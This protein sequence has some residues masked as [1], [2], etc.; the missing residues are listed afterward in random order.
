MGIENQSKTGE[1]TSLAKTLSEMRKPQ[2]A[3][4]VVEKAAVQQLRHKMSDVGAKELANRDEDGAFKEVREAVGK[5]KEVSEKIIE[6]AAIAVPGSQVIAAEAVLKETAKRV[7]KEIGKAVVKEVASQAIDATESESLRRIKGKIVE[8]SAATVEKGVDG[9]YSRSGDV[10]DSIPTE[11]PYPRIRQASAPEVDIAKESTAE[12]ETEGRECEVVGSEERSDISDDESDVVADK[13]E[14]ANH[15]TEKSVEEGKETPNLNDDQVDDATAYV[16]EI[17]PEGSM[18]ELFEQIAMADGDLSR[19]DDNGDLIKDPDG[20][21]RPEIEFEVNGT[22]YTTDERGRITHA[23]GYLTDTPDN[24]RDNSAQSEAGGKDRKPGDDGGHLRARMNGGSSGNENLVAMRDTINRGDY[25]R[26]ENEENQMLKDG[27]QVYETIDVTYDDNSS[28][29]SKIEK[30]YTDGEKT[31]KLTVDNV[32]GSTD[33]LEKLNGEISDQDLSNLTNEIE[34]MRADGNEVSVTSVRKEYD[35]DG[36]LKSVTACVTNETTGEK[37]Y[38][39]YA[40][41]GEKGS[42]E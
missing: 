16:D 12:A 3:A 31:V 2:D 37:D 25:K 36:N 23:E 13:I 22:R 27:K 33:L 42:N 39:T 20:N 28:R 35:G 17:P 18:E 19:L 26:S 7:A 30:T 24:E 1:A 21:L 15:V 40:P 6:A 9:A 14:A 5:V 11:S 29:P 34:D 8:A 38:T 32:E 4:R 10:I 41:N